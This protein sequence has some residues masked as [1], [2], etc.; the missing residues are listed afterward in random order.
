MEPFSVSIE[1][2]GKLKRKLQITV[3]EEVVRDTYNKSYSSLKDKVNIPG[4]RKGRY[5]QALLEKRFQKQMGQEALET[6]VP[7]YFEKAL[8][9]ES[10]EL[11]GRPQ[12]SNL[13]VD[14]RKPLVFSATFELRPDFEI[15]EYSSFQLEKRSVEVTSEDIE[16]RRSFH[17]EQATV[18]RPVDG[19]RVEEG[20]QV[21]IDCMADSENEKI[22]SRKNFTYTMGSQA[23]GPEVDGALIGMNAGEQKAIEVRYAD[24]HAVEGLQGAFG[25]MI[26]GVNEVKRKVIPKLDEEFFRR[27]VDVKTEEDFEGFLKKEA[28]EMKAYENKAE[29]RKRIREQLA[30]K[31]DFELPEQILAEEIG[32]RKKQAR[33]GDGNDSKSDT[34]CETEIKKKAQDDLRFSFC[35]QKVLKQENIQINEEEVGKRFQLNCMLVGLNPHDTANKELVRHIYRE[36]H[37]VVAEET[38]LDFVTEKI[39][40]L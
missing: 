9:Q 19:E 24:D 27:F 30:D 21:V 31:L 11:V 23:L 13:E 10:M 20:D 17:L 34:E 6:L 38:V 39:F 4:F 37:G 32:F 33:K 25:T 15:P 36:T 7:E 18:Y 29:Y 2:L 22:P 35:V 3:P 26:L 28:A 14:R 12:F 1:N 16:K 5:P 8:K 40:A